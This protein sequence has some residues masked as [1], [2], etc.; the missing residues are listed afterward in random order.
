MEETEQCIHAHA[1]TIV[2]IPHGGVTL[3][4]LRCVLLSLQHYYLKEMSA[5]QVWQV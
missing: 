4:A 5:L 3:I 1:K 2:H